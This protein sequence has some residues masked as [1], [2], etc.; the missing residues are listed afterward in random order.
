LQDVFKPESGRLRKHLSAIINF[1]KYRE[2]KALAFQNLQ[3][4]RGHV[5][6]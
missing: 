4:G 1:A 5:F 2:D 3:V 6:L